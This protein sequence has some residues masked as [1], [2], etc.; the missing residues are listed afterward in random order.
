MT[1]KIA[2][3]LPDA[4][5]RMARAAVKAGK[6]LNVSDYIA[7]LIEDASATETFGEMIASWLAESRTTA[8]Q[9]RAAE[10][11]SRT[12]FARAGLAPRGDRREIRRNAN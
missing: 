3:C 1:K 5:L 6:A 4:T 7:Q 8:Q 9:V 11:E 12:A 10:K 2:I